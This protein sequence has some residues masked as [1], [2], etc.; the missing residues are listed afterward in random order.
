[1]KIVRSILAVVVGWFVSALVIFAIQ[2]I[3]TAIYGPDPDKPLAERLETI[4]KMQEDPAAMKAFGESMPVS[5]LVLVL[6]SWQAGAFV[7]GA[8]SALI[9]GR[10][11]LIHAGIIGGLVLA[12]TIYTVYDMKRKFDFAHPDWM[13]VAALLLPLP[14]SLLAGQVVSI[15][16]PDPQPPPAESNP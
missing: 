4:K 15:L 2:I 10:G 9:A 7:G 5:A 12:A 8:L 1:M 11:R 3:N 13:I 16:F 6:V 14:L